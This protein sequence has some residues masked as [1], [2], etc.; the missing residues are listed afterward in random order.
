MKVLSEDSYLL[1]GGRRVF[2][3]ASPVEC[4]RTFEDFVQAV[5]KEIYID[6]EKYQIDG[7]EMHMPATPIK[8]GEFIGILVK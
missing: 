3:I 8:V 1:S 7:V 6:D 2:I 5:G 4:K